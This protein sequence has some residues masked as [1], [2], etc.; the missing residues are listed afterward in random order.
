M[1][2]RPWYVHIHSVKSICTQFLYNI[3][4][5]V[6]SCTTIIRNMMSKHIYAN[7]NPY[8]HTHFG[9]CKN[10]DYVNI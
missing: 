8:M 9:D 1:V 7:Y 6:H 3:Q 2:Y 5:T 10:R 4:Y